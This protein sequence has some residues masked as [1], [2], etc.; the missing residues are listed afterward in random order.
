MRIA[1]NIGNYDIM[2]SLVHKAKEQKHDIKISRQK[3]QIFEDIGSL[4]SDAYILSSSTDYTQSAVN[5]IKTNNPYIP[6]VITGEVEVTKITGA[7]IYIPYHKEFDMDKFAETLLA[8]VLVYNERFDKLQR[9]TTKIFKNVEFQGLV[10][11]PIKRTL[12]RDENVLFKL[13]GKQSKVLEILGTYF[14]KVVRREVILESIWQENN[15]F[16]SRSL[17]TYCSHLRTYFRANDLDLELTN[18]PR[19]GLI[20]ITNEMKK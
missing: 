15:Y 14:G 9:L 3:S 11:N 6:V 19:L 20:L 4:D 5:Q 17:D 18:V 12:S 1:I 2:N 13:S 8:N 7:D 16:V 10:F